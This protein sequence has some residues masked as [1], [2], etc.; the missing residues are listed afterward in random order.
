[1]PSLNPAFQKIGQCP[2]QYPGECSLDFADDLKQD[3]PGITLLF[4]TADDL[5][6]DL[7]GITLLFVTA[8]DL[9]QD[10][11]GITLLFVRRHG[12]CPEAARQCAKRKTL[13]G[14]NSRSVSV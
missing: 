10:L 8:D 5:K 2:K 3:L 13:R 6:Q 4:V 14:Q 1:M 11:S 9:K 12:G 7:P